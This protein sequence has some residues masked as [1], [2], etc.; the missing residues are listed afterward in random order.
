L[1]PARAPELNNILDKSD[2]P[3]TVVGNDGPPLATARVV[4]TAIGRPLVA[5]S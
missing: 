5:P 2:L 3:M 4:L 1:A